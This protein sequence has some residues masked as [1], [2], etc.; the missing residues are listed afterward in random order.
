MASASDNDKVVAASSEENRA[1][2]ADI[3]EEVINQLSAAVADSNA[4][5]TKQSQEKEPE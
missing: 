1:L 2:L 4:E 3:P 5:E